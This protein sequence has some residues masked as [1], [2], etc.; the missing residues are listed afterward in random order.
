MDVKNYVR[1]TYDAG[2]A[3][4]IM[5]ILDGP[6]YEMVDFKRTSMFQKLVDEVGKDEA[7][8]LRTMAGNVN[9]IPF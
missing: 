7:Q 4:T 1:D 5:R 3:Q 2:D 8:K 9:L 6:A